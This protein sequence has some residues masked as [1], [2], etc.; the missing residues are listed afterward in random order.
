MLKKL[1]NSIILIFT[2]IAFSAVNSFAAD[3]ITSTERTVENIAEGVYVIRHKDAPDGFPQGNTT[4]VIGEREVLV[5]DSCYLPSSAK[6]DIADIRKWTNKPVRYLVNTHWHYDHTLGNAAYWEAFAPNLTVVAHLQTAIQSAGHNPAWFNRYPK[7]A[8]SY[9][10]A[11]QTGKTSSGKELTE[12]QKKEFNKVVAGVDAVQKEFV[13][14]NDRHPNLTFS[15][16]LNF[17]L[18]NREVQ[19]KNLGRGNTAGDA[20]VYLPKEKILVTGDLLVSPVPYMF[21]GYPSDFTKTLQKMI[22]I[23]AQTI[24]PG[25]GKIFREGESGRA[26]MKKVSD[27]LQAVIAAVNKESFRIGTGARN[28]EAVQKAVKSDAQI[29][30]WKQRFAGD[31]KANQEFYETVLTAL[32]AAA[33]TEVTYR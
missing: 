12:D 25:H 18:G 19:I 24:V 10:Q 20:I 5:V 8:D 28:L 23:D 16:E 13:T 33:H 14:I 26:Y 2:F 6:E 4:V 17:D 15:D 11:L 29:S 31:N 1:L 9:K 30:T 21:G 27:F 3:S 22:F 32:I 7:N